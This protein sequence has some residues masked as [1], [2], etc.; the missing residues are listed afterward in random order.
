MRTAKNWFE[1]DRVGLAKVLARRG[2]EFALFEL[3]QNAWDEPG[4][5]TVAVSLESKGHGFATFTVT[6]D[7]P[8]GFKNLTDAYTM[9]AESAKKR[10]PEQRGRFNIG[11]K[12]VLAMAKEATITTTTGTIHFNERGRHHRKERRECGSEVSVTFRMTRQEVAAAGEHFKRLLVPPTIR[13]TVNGGLLSAPKAVA[14]FECVLPTEIAGA[15]GM[16]AKAKRKTKV[17]AYQA[18]DTMPAAIYEMGIPV[19]EIDG[20]WRLDVGQKIPLTI[21]RENVSEGF[22]KTL[23]VETFN[24][25][26][27]LMGSDDFNATWVKEAVEH[28]GATTAAVEHFVRARHGDKVVSYDPSD[29]EANKRAVA[30]GFTVLQGGSM[31]AAAWANVR[32]TGLVRPA[33]Q[34]TPSPKPFAAD[35]RP[36]TLA[37]EITGGM[38]EVEDYAKRIAATVLGANVSVTFAADT[39]WPFEATYG[40]NRLTFNAGRLGQKWF[41]LAGNRVAIDDLLIHEFGHHY[42]SDHLSEDYYRALT[43]IAAR[44]IDAVRKGQL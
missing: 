21:D 22:K 20:P 13:M 24:A 7:A 19:C 9:F 38:R 16:L 2:K 4:V 15:D 43:S 17:R 6:D 12:L 36:M 32:A 5:T 42:A 23:A 8:A 10:N 18:N 31:S 29:A 28:P 39:S 26:H 35:G 30:A 44:F 27:S 1:I 3:V 25:L 11:E 40:Q 41:D 34:V 37:K 14:E 33:G